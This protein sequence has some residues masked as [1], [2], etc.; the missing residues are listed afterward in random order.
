[1]PQAIRLIDAE[2]RSCVYV[3]IREAPGRLV[4]HILLPFAFPAFE[5]L[6]S[7]LDPARSPTTDKD[8]AP[9]TVFPMRW[10]EW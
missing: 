7:L 3:P 4:A 1:M 8:V 2:G 10:A 9:V 5:F 6:N